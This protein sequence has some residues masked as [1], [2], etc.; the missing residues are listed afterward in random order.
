M[1]VVLVSQEQYLGI[2]RLSS[3]RD[4]VNQSLAVVKLVGRGVNVADEK[5]FQN[6]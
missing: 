1:A 3:L 2:M 4:E 5:D 6:A